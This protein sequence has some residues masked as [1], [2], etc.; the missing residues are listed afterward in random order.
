MAGP[1][2]PFSGRKRVDRRAGPCPHRHHDVGMR[3]IRLIEHALA[4][5]TRRPQSQ[6]A[7]PGSE[8]ASAFSAALRDNYRQGGHAWITRPCR[9][10]DAARAAGRR[11]RG[12]AFCAG[13]ARGDV[14]GRRHSH[15]Q[16]PQLRLVVAARLAAVPDGRARL[17]RSRWFG[18]DDPSARAELLLLSPSFLVPCLTHDGIKVWDTL[19]IAEYLNE[20]KPEAGL[21]P[22]D[23]AARAHCRAIS[24][25]MHSGFSNLRSA[26]PMNLRAH[27]PALQ[28]V[29]RRAGRHRPRH[30]DLARVPRQIRRAVPVRRDA[31]DGGRD[32]RAGRARAS[33]PTTS[34]STPTAPPTAQP[35]WRCPRCRNGSRTRSRSPRKS[36]SS[37]WSSER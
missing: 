25:E 24:G 35:S 34:S 21:L 32:V 18:L 33:S 22:K 26:L 28:G 13:P 23:R 14:H 3:L 37:T 36:K 2:K 4:P 5:R 1:E 8:K 27:Y 17:S 20:L 31:D 9:G 6:K 11:L 19:A 7:Q 12:G 10:L 30:R 16:Q 29:G 15:H